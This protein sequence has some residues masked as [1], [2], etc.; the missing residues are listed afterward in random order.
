VLVVTYIGDDGGTSARAQGGRAANQHPAQGLGPP[1]SLNPYGTPHFPGHYWPYPI[2]DPT[3]DE[4]AEVAGRVYRAVQEEWLQRAETTPRPGGGRPDVE[5]RS[6]LELAERLGPWSLRWREAQDHAARSRAA[7]YQAMSDHLGRMSALE[8]GRYW[9]ETARASGGPAEPKPPGVS[10]EVARFF[11]P[12]DEW[13]IDR[14]VP[15]P[16]PSERPLNPLE[17]AVTPAEQL[18]IAGRVFHFIRDDAADRFLASTRGGEARREGGAIFDAL[19]AERLGFWSEFWSRSQEVAAQDLSSRSPAARDRSAPVPSAGARLAGRDGRTAAIRAHIERMRELEDSRFVD[20]A[21]KRA[22]RAAVEPI[23]MTRFREFAEVVR[24]FRIEAE[25]WLPGA[26]RPK[27]ADVTDSDQAEIAGRIYRAILD[28][29][30]R[31]YR[32]APRVGGAAPDVRLVFDARL[33]ERL[34]AWSTRWARARIRADASRASQFT[35]VR[36]HL[37]R[38]ASLEDGRSLHEALERAGLLAGGPAAPVPPREFADVARFF[39]LE[40][41]WELEQLKSR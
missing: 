13:G 11:R 39:R 41:L 7:R 40:V 18:E 3:A 21:F 35:A 29:A 36:S 12:F 24:F 27:G 32:E 19:L 8:D 2:K 14:I 22:G 4:R 30:A 5:A 28:G 33:A 37:A 31:R 34:A 9:R 38:M 17:V 25:S 1:Y 16:P 20:D 10:A 6:R 15:G 23:D 26:S